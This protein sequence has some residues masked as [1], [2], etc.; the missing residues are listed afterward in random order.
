MGV[1]DQDMGQWADFYRQFF[2]VWGFNEI[3]FFV[4]IQI[5]IWWFGLGIVDFGFVFLGVQGFFVFFGIVVLGIVDKF[6]DFIIIMVVDI[7]DFG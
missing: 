1:I 7:V 4:D 5:I 2:L 3:V 6:L